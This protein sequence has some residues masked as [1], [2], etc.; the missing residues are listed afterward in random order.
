MMISRS[1]AIATALLL[2]CAA[3]ARGRSDAR[4]AF[5]AGIPASRRKI[6]AG[7]EAARP[8]LRPHA[9][10]G[11]VRRAPDL[12]IYGA[13]AR[14]KLEL[15][16]MAPVGTRLR[17]EHDVEQQDQLGHHLAYVYLSR[18]RSLNEALLTAGM[19]A[20]AEYPPTADMPSR[21]RP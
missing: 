9:Q 4:R 21:T 20:F 19:A 5:R 18:N 13:L 14:A 15:E 11:Q 2:V 16:R 3:S 8:Q 7:L 6:L 1:L 10:R 12:G 17:V